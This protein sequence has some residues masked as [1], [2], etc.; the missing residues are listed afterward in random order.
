MLKNTLKVSL[1]ICSI[2][3]QSK[4]TFGMEIEQ[5]QITHSNINNFLE[6]YKINIKD[7]IKKVEQN[8][9]IFLVGTTGAGKST[10]INFL[11]DPKSLEMEQEKTLVLKKEYIGNDFMI[12]GTGDKSI[13]KLPQSTS[14]NYKGKHFL[15]YDLP[16]LR[17]T[18][19]CATEFVNA[20]M[21][22]SLVEKARSSKIIFTVDFN[23]INVERGNDVLEKDISKIK[24]IF[25][26]SDNRNI[27]IAITKTE[28]AHPSADDFLD[29]LLNEKKMTNLYNSLRNQWQERLV[30]KSVYSVNEED[31]SIRLAP[32]H[33]LEPHQLS[34]LV[35][36]EKELIFSALEKISNSKIA[37]VN[38]EAMYTKGLEEKLKNI[39]NE[40][41]K[42]QLKNA[43]NTLINPIR[44]ILNK[45]KINEEQKRNLNNFI[46]QPHR[47]HRL[48][49]S[50]DEN[51]EKSKLNIFLSESNEQVWNSAR[52]SFDM[53]LENKKA[54]FHD[55]LN[56]F[57]NIYER[58]HLKT[59]LN[60]KLEELKNL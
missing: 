26:D 59:Q 55:I 52:G 42:I 18:R 9:C 60:K 37:K 13:T 15:I 46:N 24:A 28:K 5:E 36:N 51:L 35:N 40:E 10:L 29:Y 14:V 23:K 48:K 11:K 17:D 30:T 1:V 54:K 3:L 16:G 21:I 32:I 27:L 45:D 25:P 47:D 53:I 43:S 41:F 2:V 19:G 12:T 50:F 44:D 57:Y 49:N 20:Y 56:R 38:A 4:T 33:R 34:K 39:I 58:D 8:D 31:L 6:E 7:D 22:K